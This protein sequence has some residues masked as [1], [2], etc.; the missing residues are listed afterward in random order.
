MFG[1]NVDYFGQLV[2]DWGFEVVLF[3]LSLSAYG[4]VCR[5]G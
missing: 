4:L 2:A 1:E 5:Q 3:V